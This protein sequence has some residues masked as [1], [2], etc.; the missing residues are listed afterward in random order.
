MKKKGFT[1]IEMVTAIAVLVIIISFA[2][3]IFK[4]SIDSYRTANANTEIMQKLRAITGQLNKDF[5]GLCKDGYL[6]IQHVHKNKMEYPYSSV[7]KQGMWLDRIYYFSTGDF[8]SWFNPDI[9]SNISRVFMGHDANSTLKAIPLSECVL[10]RDVI[11][12]TPGQPSLADT[13]NVSFAAC[14][15]AL[16]NL[17]KENPIL[18]LSVSADISDVD[19]VRRFMCA[20]VGEIKIEWTDGYIDINNT[21]SIVWLNAF[22]KGKVG[23][24][25]N[26]SKWPKAIKFTFTLYDSK[27]ILKEG[28]RFTH[29]VY[30]GD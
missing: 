3:V 25:P 7:P 21:K 1:L 13:N 17:E 22:G 26:T 2:S 10:A 5:E 30:L 20:N 19:N 24:G 23:W 18:D 27:G 11:L 4:A 15:S 16:N 12:L 28:R 6:I 9:K 29:I 14:K 8:Q